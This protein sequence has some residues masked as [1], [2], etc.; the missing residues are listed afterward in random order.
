MN[1]HI[2]E[3]QQ[4]MCFCFSEMTVEHL[5]SGGHMKFRKIQIPYHLADLRK[6]GR[7]NTVVKVI[8]KYL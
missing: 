3:R 6:S 7:I 2:I 5:K 1:F 8:S 4:K